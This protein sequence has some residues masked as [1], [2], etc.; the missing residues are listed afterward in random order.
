MA[1][2]VMPIEPQ[3]YIDGNVILSFGCLDFQECC[4]RTDS[5]P[6]ETMEKISFSNLIR[7]QSTEMAGSTSGRNISRVKPLFM[8]QKAM[9]A[10]AHDRCKMRITAPVAIW[11][12][13]LYTVRCNRCAQSA[14]C[15]RSTYST[16]CNIALTV[17]LL[18]R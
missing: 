7:L 9:S 15:T 10:E 13:R 18:K 5:V 12:F 17:Y 8:F 4:L 11:P 3:E 6:L 16:P 1:I 2:S 14:G